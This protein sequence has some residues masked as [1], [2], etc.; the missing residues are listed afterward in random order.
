MKD[1]FTADIRIKRRISAEQFIQQRPQGINIV[2][3]TGPAAVK[4][5]RAH[6]KQRTAGRNFQGIVAGFENAGNAKISQPGRF[7]PVE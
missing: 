4:L 1:F 7:V 5:L 6:A 2:R 3:R